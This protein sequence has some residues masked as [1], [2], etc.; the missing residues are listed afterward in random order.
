MGGLIFVSHA[1]RAI[2]CDHVVINPYKCKRQAGSGKMPTILLIKK[3]W[4]GTVRSHSIA[5]LTI[6]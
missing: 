1:A 6:E 2:Q 3:G 4:G 5:M